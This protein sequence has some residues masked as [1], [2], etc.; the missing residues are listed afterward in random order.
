MLHF[1]AFAARL[2]PAFVVC[3]ILAACGGGDGE[4]LPAAGNAGTTPVQT[5]PAPASPAL[6]T[7]PSA[8]SSE[9]PTTGEAGGGAASPNRA[10][11]ITGAPTATATVGVA[12]SFVPTAT[13]ADGDALGFSIR[14]RPAWATFNTAT[15]ALA[16]T[17]SEA[18][19][20]A[21]IV[22]S[23]SDGKSSSA[24]G[25]FDITVQ[26]ATPL[27]P[28]AVLPTPG[29]GL[30]APMEDM[31]ALGP[32]PSWSVARDHG[33][34]GDGVA[35]DTNALQ[36]AINELTGSGKPY[37]LRLGAGTYRITRSLVIKATAAGFGL[38]IIGDDP[39][40]TRIVWDGPSG[41]PMLI[42]DGG[43]FSTFARI[44]WDGRG[45]AGYG[46]AHWWNSTG[47]QYGGSAEHLDEVFMDMGIGIQAGRLG[48]NYGQLDSEGQVRRVKFVRNTRAGLNVGSWNALDW[49]VW[50]SEFIDCARG[51]SNLF[52]VSD[53]PGDIGAGN[54]IVYRSVFR[55]STVA[56]MHI[57]NT[58]WFAAHNNVSTG[59]RRFFQADE[60]GRNAALVVL[61]SNRVVD[62]TDPTAVYVGNLGP[63]MLI[64]NQF[65]SPVGAGGPVVRLDG[66]ASGREAIAVGNRFTVSNRIGKR[67]ASDRVVDI[68]SEVVARESIPTVVPMLPPTPARQPRTVFEV[69]RGAGGAAIQAA[70]DNAVAAANAGAVN[71]VVHLPAGNYSLDRTLV[72]PGDVRLQIAGDSIGTV[73][74]WAGAGTG[75]MLRLSGPSKATVR[76]LRLNAGSADA[77]SIEGAD[78]AGGRVFVV[79]SLLGP[80]DAAGLS[81]TRLAL[82]ANTTLASIRLDGVASAISQGAGGVGPVTLRQNS[83]FLMS[84]TWYEGRSS[85]LFRVDSGTFT[86]QSGAIAPADAVHGGGATEPAVLIDNLRGRVTVIGMLMNLPTPENGIR[87]GA[88]LPE[89]NALFLGVQSNKGE[90]FQRTSTQAGSVG[91]KSSKYPAP[92]SGTLQTLA[93]DVGRTDDAFLRDSLA[94][95]RSVTWETAPVLAPPGATDVRIYKVM[96]MQA[97]NALLIRR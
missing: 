88:E 29:N 53:N 31:E 16:G 30:V 60:A 56:D 36:A 91:L 26:P 81:Q 61:Q 89:T 96:A 32:F 65:R 74:T 8:P 2:I 28:S 58:G 1:R 95:T 33:A 17:P 79:G 50:D 78:Q 44:T 5:T 3:T 13:D 97:R 39:A 25:P 77:I 59:S 92:G 23:A 73:I 9:T 42:V 66:N 62:F 34:V 43:L 80:V 14:N 63:M 87:I 46:V 55:R 49:W 69:A 40:T 94:Q 82:Q 4:A 6:P 24:L 76:D 72:V 12:Y 7:S 41:D 11:V 45:R 51:V 15:G 84:E 70:I 90:F 10:P 57:A 54:F 67:E 19:V 93:P 38:G 71:P 18:G 47:P 48:A 27:P 86:Y 35:D 85:A 52:T 21:G 22:I 37:V 75:P 20:H 68:D 64:D 83:N